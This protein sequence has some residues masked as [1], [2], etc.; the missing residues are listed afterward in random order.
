MFMK[1]RYTYKNKSFNTIQQLDDFL[2]EKQ[3]YEDKYGDL[4]FS[5]TEEQLPAQAKIDKINQDADDLNK[6]YAE[7]KKNAQYVDSEE[8][9]KMTRPFVGVSEFLMGQRNDKGNLW[10]PEFTTEYWANQYLNWSQGI[11]SE[12]QIDVFF[13]GDKSKVQPLDL[14][15]TR[16]W[17]NNDGTLKDSFGSSEQNKF[18]QLMEDKWKHQAEYGNDIHAIMQSYFAHVGTDAGGS[19]K[20]RYEL[21][22]G[23]QGAMQLAKSIKYMRS[24]HLI[25]DSMDDAKINSILG[26]A[27]QLREQLQSVHG[28]KCLFYPEI[29]VSAK[30]NHEY[31]GRDDLN[32]LGRLDLLVIDEKGVPHIMDYKTSP[33]SYDNFNSAKRL[34]FTYQLSTYERMLRRYGFRT[35]ATTLN[36]I[37]LQLDNYRNEGGKWVYDD[38]KLGGNVL[39]SITDDANKE[40]IANNLDEYIEAPLV[41]DGD[42]AHITEEVTNIMKTWFPE[43]GNTMTDEQIKKMIDNQGGFVENADA[44]TLE[45]KPKGWTKTISVNNK[46]GAEAELF[47]KIKKFFTGQRERSIKRTQ[48][49]IRAVKQAQAEDTRQVQ[50][51]NSMSDWAKTKL[52]KYCSKSWEIMDGQAQ[53]VAEKFGMI[54]MYNR[55]NNLMEIVKVSSAD[56]QYQH[57][58]GQ[59]RQNIIGAKE[60]DLGENSKSDSLIIKATNGNIELMEAMAVLNNLNFNADVK[61]GNISVI[62]PVF[63]QG[64]E[65]N[66][67]KE[68]LYNWRKLRQVYDI[69]GDDKFSNDGPLQLLSLAERT[70]LEYA[71]IMDRVNDRWQ[72]A[73]FNKFQPVMTELNDAIIPNNIEDS[74]AALTKLKD[75]L[76]KDFAMNKDILTKGENKGKSIYSEMQNYDQSYTKQMYQMVLRSIAELS[77]FDIRQEVKAHS[78]W[79]DSLNVLENGMSGNMLDNPG[80]F[81][82]Q[83]LN[84]VTAL[85][86]DGYQNTRDMSI[87]RLNELSDKVR[88]LKRAE[89]YNMAKEYTIG[90]Q[91]DLYQGMT[92]FDTDG[93]FKFKNPW[94][95]NSMTEG[96]REFLKYALTQF[97]KNKHPEW[98]DQVI[99]DKVRANDPDFFQVPLIEASSASRISTDGF[100]GWVKGKLRPF[101]SKSNGATFKERIQNTLKDFQSKWL[102]DN[103]D[104]QQSLDGEVFKAMNL[105]DQGNGAGRIDLIKRLQSK[106]GVNCFET[107]IEKLLGVHMMSYATQQAMKDRMPLIKAAYVSLAVMGNNQGMDYSSDEK[108]IKEYVQ[109]KI[110]HISIVDPKLKHLKGL[111]GVGQKAASWMA[112]A[113]SPLQMTY[114]SLEGVWKAGKLVITKPDGKETFSFKN[115]REAMGIVYKDLAHFSETPSVISA[116]NSLYGINDMDAASF[117]QNNSTNKHGM[118]NF[119]DR[120]AYHWASRPDYYNRMSIFTAQMLADGSYEAHSVDKLGNLVYDMK[121]DKRFEALFNS[122]KGSA[123]YNKAKALYLTIAQQL[124]REG[125]RNPDGSKYVIDLDRPN[126]PKAYSNKES[127]AMKSIGDTMYGYYDS[128]KKSLWQSTFLGGLMMQMQT[129]WSGKKNQYLAP[130]GIKAQGKW[131]QMESPNGKKC[132]YSKNEAGDID[133]SSMPVEEGDP[134]ASDVPFMQWKGKFEEGVFITL[135]DMFKRT[136]GHKGNIKQAWAEKLDGADEDLQKLYKQN[137]KLMASDLF[138][139]FFIGSLLGGLLGGLTDDEIKN[140]KAT[141]HFEDALAATSMSL[142]AKTVQNSALDFNMIDSLFGW[143]TDWNPF[144]IGYITNQCSNAFEFMTGDKNAVSTLCSGFSAARQMRPILQCINSSIQDE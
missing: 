21:W 87:R 2:L 63:G 123:E 69:Q 111:F 7:A 46:P 17:R 41:I 43:Q 47:N 127:E 104:Q 144:S 37:P 28:S 36:I 81:G 71:D 70:Y 112:L 13:D 95:D 72:K 125:A 27:K 31:E 93:D 58:W 80:N 40:N 75:K 48:E 137:M 44:G 106:R 99:Q 84:Q 114:Q 25:S 98:T 134:R 116:C 1:C 38:V 139:L 65:T 20:Y 88:A 19:P 143:T 11:Y 33:K 24:K 131:V 132:F 92:Y 109:N 8:V 102:S 86:L 121:K 96:K 113:F 29:T 128:S 6:R 77:G 140:A 30:L 42:T 90:N 79:I 22:E 91:A 34:T 15:N 76:E 101:I 45:F 23:P 130:G 89:D 115:M 49:I 68:L 35:D 14:G 129:Y 26:I 78:N 97:A 57:S 74:L 110:N 12:D 60:A 83:L 142:I 82:N 107:D 50:L 18:R 5:L 85:A 103:I 53:N 118:F 124:V 135:Y 3:I 133:N 66:S 67:N 105:M 126:L 16:D 39:E 108:Y 94:T 32:V 136:L 141:G 59:G 56:L 9:L 51:P 55:A 120:L 54:L 52:S 10:L 119:M 61:V 100:L 62:N 64:A 4:V 117:A 73:E 138:G 122:P